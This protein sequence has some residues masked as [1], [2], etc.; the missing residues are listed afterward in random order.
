MVVIL[1]EMSLLEAHINQKYIQLEKY[2][3]LLRMS[4]DSLLADHGLDRKRYE[5]SVRFYGQNAALYLQIHDSVMSKLEQGKV[6]DVQ[7]NQL[8][9]MGD[10]RR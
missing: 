9:R 10:Y 8:D 4:G 2:A 1:Y 6:Q 3:K 7:S 5:E